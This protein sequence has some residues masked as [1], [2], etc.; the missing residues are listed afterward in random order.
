MM[1]KIKLDLFL[2]AKNFHIQDVAEPVAQKPRKVLINSYLFFFFFFSIL[3]I[4]CKSLN[5]Q[6]HYLKQEVD[7]FMYRGMKHFRK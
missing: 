5:T 1:V 4:Y 6:I 3:V 7:Q 2:V